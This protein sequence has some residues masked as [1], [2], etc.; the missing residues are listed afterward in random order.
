MLHFP[1]LFFIHVPLGFLMATIVGSTGWAVV[2]RCVGIKN[3]DIKKC[4]FRPTPPE[5]S[6]T[7]VQ[8]SSTVSGCGSPLKGLSCDGLKGWA[9]GM[10]LLMC[11]WTDPL[12]QSCIYCNVV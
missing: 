4:T 7:N 10:C 9:S 11:Y 6:C 5:A 12:W 2:G 1:D 3:P 8:T